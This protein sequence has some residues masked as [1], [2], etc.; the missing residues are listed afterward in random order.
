MIKNR[1][2]KP[3][4]AFLVTVG[5]AALAA[6]FFSPGWLPR[7]VRIVECYDAGLV[8]MLI[9]YWHTIFYT[10]A[11]QAKVYAAAEDPGRDVAFVLTLMAIAFGFIAA[12]GILA[13]GLPD[14]IA[15]HIAVVEGVGFG[16]VALGW[17]LIHTL[18]SFRYAHLYYRDTD[19]DKESDRGLTFPGGAEPDYMDLAYFSFVIGMTFQV[20]DVQITSKGIRKYVLGHGLI[21]F[22]Y[23]TAILALVVNVVSGLLH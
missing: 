3:I 2:L 10:K 14:R 15:G 19:R 23:N 17:L 9:W 22:C 6:R 5:I 16:A 8:A 1:A 12:F 20:S 13:H 11:T 21:S 18:F 4:A 7:E